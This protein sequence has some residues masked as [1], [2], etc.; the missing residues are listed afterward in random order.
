MKAFIA[1]VAAEP[2]GRVAKYQDFDTE[3][4]AETHIAVHSGLFAAPSP[5]GNITHY[6][7]VAGALVLD[8]PV[9]QVQ[10]LAKLVISGRFTDAEIDVVN[11]LRDGSA[12]IALPAQTQKRLYRVWS[13]AIS[14]QP[15]DARTAQGFA[16][17]FGAARAKALLAP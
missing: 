16:A 11:A 17:I 6:K 15:D 3:A 14:I 1:I 4:D 8:P 5:A 13:D 9:E 12:A 7:V 10:P 2:S